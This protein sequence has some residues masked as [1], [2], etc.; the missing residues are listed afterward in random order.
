VPPVIDAVDVPLL[1][2]EQEVLVFVNEETD[3]IGLLPIVVVET[4]EQAPAV[5]VKV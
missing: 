5:T 2:E 3:T 1:T 4:W